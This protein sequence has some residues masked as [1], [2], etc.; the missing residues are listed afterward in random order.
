[1]RRGKVELKRIDNK[2]SR[3]VTF[4][5]RRNGLLKKAHELS[6]LCDAEVALI[7]FST[8]GRL[9]EFSTSSCM[10]KTLERYRSCNFNSEATATPEPELS[11]Y[12]EYLK[13]KQRV[14]F[15]Q[16]TQRNLLGEDLGPL[17][18]KELEQLENHVEISLKHIRATKSQ[19]SF[20]QLLELKRKVTHVS[21]L[22]SLQIQETSAE[23]VLQMFYQDD[24]PSGSSGHAN[25]A[26][27]QQ[28][29]H[30]DCDPSLRMIM[31]TWIT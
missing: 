26:N 20:D 9:F 5:K 27:Q 14:E 19:Q 8:R 23:S 6:V 24:G 30:P 25:Q 28:H 22:F 21:L 15:L 2:S 12:Q 16:T 7:I 13:L 18:M 17:N 4:A 11:G 29:V 10:Y 31:L 3:Q 1:M